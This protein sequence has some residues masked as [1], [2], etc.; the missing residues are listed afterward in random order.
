MAKNNAVVLACGLALLALP[1]QAL[2]ENHRVCVTWVWLAGEFGYT[3]ASPRPA[4]VE[5]NGDFGG[6]DDG[7]L[8]PDWENFGETEGV[9]AD[10]AYGR[11]DAPEEFTAREMLVRVRAPAGVLWGWKPLD[12]DG[13]TEIF[14]TSEGTVALDWVS[15]TVGS[16]HIVALECDTLFLIAGFP[17]PQRC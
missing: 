6:S 1:S 10:D 3:D 5:G 2:A 17:P 9:D 4:V 8:E 14:D 12:E 11:R 7:V 16:A 13:C 15:W